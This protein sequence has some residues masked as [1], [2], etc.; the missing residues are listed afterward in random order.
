MHKPF[1]LRER[2]AHIETGRPVSAVHN[3]STDHSIATNRPTLTT[4]IY[5]PSHLNHTANE[6]NILSQP[7]AQDHL[8]LLSGAFT[9]PH[10]VNHSSSFF[11]HPQF[12]TFRHQLVAHRLSLTPAQFFGAFPLLSKRHTRSSRVITPPCR[13]LQTAN[14]NFLSLNDTLSPEASM[15]QRDC[16]DTYPQAF[17]DFW[18]LSSMYFASQPPSPFGTGPSFRLN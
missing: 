8:T 1:L 5:F 16:C 9:W 3:T 14:W 6:K 2:E 10:R 7:K 4:T 17:P 13:R 11:T 12:F 15:S 18:R